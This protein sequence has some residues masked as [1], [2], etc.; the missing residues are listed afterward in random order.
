MFKFP[1]SRKEQLMGGK[2]RGGGWISSLSLE[3]RAVCVLK[4]QVRRLYLLNVYGNG[5]YHSEEVHVV[6]NNNRHFIVKSLKVIPPI[7]LWLA[8]H[9]Y[10]VFPFCPYPNF[11]PNDKALKNLKAPAT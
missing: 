9:A 6:E 7:Q 8:L 10:L 2:G 1:D 4:I 3:E 11:T 5:F